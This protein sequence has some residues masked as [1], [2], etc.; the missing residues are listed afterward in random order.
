[1]STPYRYPRPPA[2]QP[3]PSDS[4]DEE[5]A[6]DDTMNPSL[7]SGKTD[8]ESDS[9]SSL[10]SH[11]PITGS[12]PSPRVVTTHGRAAFEI[13]E[14]SD[15]D[16]MDSDREAALKP[17]EYEYPESERSRSPARYPAEGSRGPYRARVRE[18]PREFVNS[19][20]NLDC[21]DS[22]DEF[23]ADDMEHHDFVVRQKELKRIHRIS[24]GSSIGKRTMSDRGDSDHEDLKPFENG[25]N[26]LHDRR[27]RRRV[28][29]RRESLFHDHPPE[30]IPELEE[31]DSDAEE[32][33]F[34]FARELP[35][36]DIEIMEVDSE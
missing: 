30:R 5:S 17:A 18:L 35:Y 19:M 29:E 28:G 10:G 13:E 15:F 12:R 22:D 3:S 36:Y 25:E 4:D 11:Q 14:L 31:P 6:D 32:Q 23:D 7:S 33:E 8:S 9:P 27:M 24:H 16:P 26:A 1:M 21:D 34:N 20:R 2:P